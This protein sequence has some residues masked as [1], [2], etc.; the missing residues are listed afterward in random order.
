MSD[1][2]G[3]GQCRRWALCY[4]AVVLTGP[5]LT[6]RSDREVQRGE[7]RHADGTRPPS[8][9]RNPRTSGS[10][11]VGL[12]GKVVEWSGAGKGSEVVHG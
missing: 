1:G 9:D 3:T 11:M 6:D 12:E 8:G 2:E 5:E 10:A 4:R 7:R